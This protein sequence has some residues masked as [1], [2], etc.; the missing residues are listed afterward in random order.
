MYTKDNLNPSKDQCEASLKWKT[1][2]VHYVVIKIIKATDKK[3]LNLYKD[4]KQLIEK[5]KYDD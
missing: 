3:K 4:I 2:S 5:I 1:Q